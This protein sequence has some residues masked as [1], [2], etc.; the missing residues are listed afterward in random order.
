MPFSGVFGL[1]IA[2]AG[3]L[4]VF[5]KSRNPSEHVSAGLQKG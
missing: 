2:L 4:M 1:Q 5:R 3:I